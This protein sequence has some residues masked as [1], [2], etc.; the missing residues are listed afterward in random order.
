MVTPDT[1]QWY[2]TNTNKITDNYNTAVSTDTTINMVPLPPAEP[3]EFS[4][5]ETVARLSLSQN[6]RGLLNDIQTQ[7]VSNTSILTENNM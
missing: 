5:F 1:H 6:Q 2:R 7:A 3:S 4:V